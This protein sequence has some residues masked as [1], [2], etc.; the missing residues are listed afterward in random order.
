MDIFIPVFGGIGLFLYGM[1]LMGTG[2]EHAAGD[3]LK[4]ILEKL[5]RN[6]LMSIILGAVVTMLIQ[7]SSATTVMVVGFVNAGLM[8]LVQAAGI[9]M[10]ANIGTTITSQL[11][12][13]DLS[14]YAP[15]AIGIGM[16][17][18]LTAEDKARKY[19]G[20]ILLGFGILFMGMDVMSGGLEP[21]RT[22][23]AF[24]DVLAK[25][26]NPVLGTI[27]GMLLTTVLQSSS[28]AIGI[29]QALG[30]Q[31]LV[32]MNIGIPILLGQNVGTTTTALLASVGANYTAKRAAFLH[33]MMN[34]LGAVVFLL[35]LTGPLE[36]L[37][38]FLSPGRVPRQIAN[39][40][41]IF[42]FINAAILFPFM[43]QIVKLS[44]VIIPG[45]DKARD[46]GVALDDRILATPLL[47]LELAT[48]ETIKMANAIE[49]NLDQAIKA[50]V[51]N[52]FDK[53][54][55]VLNREILINQME[56]DII[57]YLLKL[58]KTDISARQLDFVNVLLYTLNDLERV[59]DHAENI[60]ELAQIKEE[61]GT[62]FTDDAVDSIKI[63]YETV[64]KVFKNA[65]SS[66][67]E[68]DLEKV[69][70]VFLLEGQVNQMEETGKDDHM[71]R[72]RA[73]LCTTQAGVVYLDALGN[74]ER[75]S[76]HSVNI[77]NN[78]LDHA[79]RYGK[80]KK[81]AK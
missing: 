60:V 36:K 71:E 74:L 56:R 80:L 50:F 73:G 81:E 25:L 53:I 24:V 39:A 13:F 1:N 17:I 54:Q 49:E 7:S 68:L 8:N 20:E 67:E 22:N 15:I 33:F 41:T 16:I 62:L 51:D 78:L 75:I 29:L 38:V 79:K 63:M 59:G 64:K 55:G 9:I 69:E 4:N 58:S 61:D 23:P 37:V 43:D 32:N 46:E 77:A 65:V 14:K 57:E 10:G 19:K 21:L 18:L 28:A 45:E 12:A 30:G 6:K 5:T 40:H 3:K 52:E 72:L 2:L 11:I 42:N 44:T 35:F 26:Q 66:I 47:A 70:E 34:V 27:A 48:N 76:D 31:G